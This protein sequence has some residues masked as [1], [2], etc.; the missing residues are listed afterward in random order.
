MTV[1]EKIKLDEILK[2]L[3]TTSD[4][5]LIKLLNAIFEENFKLKTTIPW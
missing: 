3:F 5:V 1:K 2:R 4:K